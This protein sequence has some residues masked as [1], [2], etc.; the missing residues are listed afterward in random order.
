MSHSERISPTAYATGYYW[1]AHGLSHPAFATRQGRRTLQAFRPLMLGLQTIGGLSLDA[2]L[3]ARHRGIDEKLDAAIRSGAVSQVIEIAAGLSPRGWRF[4]QHYGKA[5]TYLDTDL[6]AMAATKRRLLAQHDLLSEHHRVV[7]LDA[8]AASGPQSLAGLADE[9]YPTAG[10][11][12][13]TEG[14]LSYLSPQDAHDLWARIAATLNRF[15]RGLYLA[16]L[17]F[18]GETHG[19]AV[20]LFGWLLSRFVRGRI[21][22]HFGHAEQARETLCS[23]GFSPAEVNQ[24]ITLASNR[25]LGRNSG[26]ERVQILS[27]ATP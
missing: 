26:A 1:Y 16:D 5:I 23:H 17:H 13:I 15:P 8:L 11:V 21:N 25:D 9:L 10:T 7:E 3:M 18:R 6:P 19:H 2:T 20:K 14:L 24:A 4:A 12:I 27:A 22:M